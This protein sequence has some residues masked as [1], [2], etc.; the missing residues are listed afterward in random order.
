MARLSG[1]RK[2][3]DIDLFKAKINEYFT[4]ENYP[5]TISGLCLHL[6][7]TR[8]TLC[9]YEKDANYFDTIKRAKLKIENYAEKLL[10]SSLTYTPG[11]IFNLKNNF[12]WVDKTE[13][14]TKNENI[15]ENKNI[16]L[17]HL[18][19]EQIKEL[20]DNECKGNT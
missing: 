4:K 8:D 20:L 18:T 5:W 2:Y 7:I 17:S 13:S 3:E 10:F 15:N 19:V 6:D 14:V 1:T 9:N 16:D 11:I 12:G